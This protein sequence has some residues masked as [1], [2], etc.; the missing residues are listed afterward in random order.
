MVCTESVL[1]YFDPKT[2]LSW[3]MSREPRGDKERQRCLLPSIMATSLACWRMH[4]AQTN[5]WCLPMPDLHLLTPGSAEPVHQA[6]KLAKLSYEMLS[7]SSC[8]S[9]CL[10]RST[11]VNIRTTEVKRILT[12]YPCLTYTWLQLM[13]LIINHYYIIWLYWY[14]TPAWQCLV[15]EA[16]KQKKRKPQIVKYIYYLTKLILSNLVNKLILR[17]SKEKETWTRY[18]PIISANDT[19]Q[20]LAKYSL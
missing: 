10:I 7:C 11:E 8:S 16:E 18:L 2:T 12:Q 19:N 9:F 20:S 1:V 14:F 5:S 6:G 4:S 17:E 15:R 3:R 13:V